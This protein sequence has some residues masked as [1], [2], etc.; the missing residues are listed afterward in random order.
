[1]NNVC[2]Y[3]IVVIYIDL[4]ILSELLLFFYRST[5]IEIVVSQ[6]IQFVILLNVDPKHAFEYVI[7]EYL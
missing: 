3:L 7:R 6:R 2:Y 1:M 5:L 4:Y